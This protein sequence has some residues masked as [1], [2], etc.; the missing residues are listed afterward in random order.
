[1]AVNIREATKR[2]IEAIAALWRQLMEYHAGLDAAFAVRPGAERL[3]RKY[4]MKWIKSRGALTLVA[5]D[6]GKV[7]AYCATVVEEF[8]A[9]FPPARAGIVAD[10][11]VDGAHRRRGIGRMLV[12]T[13]RMWLLGQGVTTMR[14]R[15]AAVNGDALAFW[16]ALGFKDFT[17]MMTRDISGGEPLGEI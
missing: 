11:I 4:V 10:L 2:D 13:A 14:L 3:F 7:V 1:V 12:E 8:P 6:A 17:I 16:R 5:S 15:A 9:A